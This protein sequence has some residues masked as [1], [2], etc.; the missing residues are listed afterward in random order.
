MLD[1]IWSGNGVSK[2]YIVH[3][4]A[5]FWILFIVIIFAIVFIGF[6]KLHRNEKMYQ[7]RMLKKISINLYID[8]KT[9]NM[10]TQFQ[11]FKWL[12]DFLVLKI[13]KIHDTHYIRNILL[14]M[15]KRLT[16][17][18]KKALTSWSIYRCYCYRY[19]LELTTQETPTLSWKNGT[20]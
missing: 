4:A 10:I 1:I 14:K 7:E 13:F 2:S 11:H 6:N 18:S 8:R 20:F 9:L 15:S 19:F 3:L 12:A 17:F 16:Q 5:M